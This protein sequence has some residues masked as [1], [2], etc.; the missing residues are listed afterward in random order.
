MKLII[1]WEIPTDA[2]NL[3]QK[4]RNIFVTYLSKKMKEK[5]YKIRNK[6]DII[7]FGKIGQEVSNFV[8]SNRELV[9]FYAIVAFVAFAS[10]AMVVV[11]EI[12]NYYDIKP[13]DIIYTIYKNW[14]SDKSQSAHR[15]IQSTIDRNKPLKNINDGVDLTNYDSQK[16]DE[17]YQK[18]HQEIVNYYHQG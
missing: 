17:K 8:A 7:D 13:C 1:D 12:L 6:M 3:I 5:F 9:V 11:A 14:R 18:N 16:N 15:R 2:I 4:F 10:L